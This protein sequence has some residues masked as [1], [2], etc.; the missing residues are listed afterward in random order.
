MVGQGLE[1]PEPVIIEGAHVR[2]AVPDQQ[3]AGRGPPRHRD[4]HRHAV[5]RS[6]VAIAVALAAVRAQQHRLTPQGRRLIQRVF[7]GHARRVA[8]LMGALTADEQDQLGR[9]CKKL[10]LAAQAT[11]SQR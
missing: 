7:P 4:R 11:R 10:G 1:E 6:A 5:N 9:L 3:H 8:D 2:Q